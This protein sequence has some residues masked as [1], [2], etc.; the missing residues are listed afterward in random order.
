MQEKN[1]GKEK[2]VELRFVAWRTL[3]NMTL[4][5]KTPDTT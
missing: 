5:G 3:K 2:R 1:E 4:S